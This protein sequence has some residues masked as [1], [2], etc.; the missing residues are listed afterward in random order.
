M[1]KTIKV[2]ALS[3]FLIF[4]TTVIVGCE[5]NSSNTSNCDPNCNSVQCSGAT[6]TGAR[7]QN[8]TKNCCGRCYLHK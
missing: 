2:V 1:K 4:S 6:Q 7:C 3:C 8:Q 5:D